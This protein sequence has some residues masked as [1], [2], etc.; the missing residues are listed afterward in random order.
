MYK[1]N[2]KQEHTFQ[3]I[4]IFVN[5]SSIA[6]H[7]FKKMLASWIL[8]P[9][10][11]PPELEGDQAVTHLDHVYEGVEVVGGHDEAVSLLYVTPA[12]QHQVPTQ[13]VLK[14]TSQV[15][16]EY[17]VQVVVVGTWRKE[18]EDINI[19]YQQGD[20]NFYYKHRDIYIQYWYNDINLQHD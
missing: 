20:I 13:T 17:R 9:E 5:R 12:P 14:G 2:E 10:L 1:P 8:T 3:S 19:Q 18:T 7:F 11:E 6:I 16:V 15:L 4:L